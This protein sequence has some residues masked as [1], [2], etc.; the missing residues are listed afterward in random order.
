MVTGWPRSVTPETDRENLPPSG[1]EEAYRRVLRA[2]PTRV[3]LSARVDLARRVYPTGIPRPA[4]TSRSTHSTRVLDRLPADAPSM[5]G[6]RVEV[7]GLEV[8]RV[9]ALDVLETRGEE[10][11]ASESTHARVRLVA[12]VAGG[13]GA[14]LLIS[15]PLDGEDRGAAFRWLRAQRHFGRLTRLADLGDNLPDLGSDDGDLRSA[16]LTEFEETLSPD[17]YLVL[18]EKEADVRAAALRPEIYLSPLL[19]PEAPVLVELDRQREAR[20]GDELS[21]LLLPLG[22]AEG[23]EIRRILTLPGGDDPIAVLRPPPLDSLTSGGE[24]VRIVWFAL[25]VVLA[26]AAMAY[27]GAQEVIYRRTRDAVAEEDERR[28]S[29]SAPRG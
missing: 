18:S 17:G 13:G 7:R 10:A 11:A 26:M 9:L 28:K 4:F 14:L 3:V 27:I 25:G 8:G 16:W 5:L 21:G 23:R 6:A 1:A 15:P 2:G 24:R 20:L 19:D 22:G 29:E 12:G